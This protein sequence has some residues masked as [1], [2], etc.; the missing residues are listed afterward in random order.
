MTIENLKQ[1]LSAFRA[2]PNAKVCVNVEGRDFILDYPLQDESLEI[3][4]ELMDSLLSLGIIYVY[5]GSF[6]VNPMAIRVLDIM[7]A[8]N[9]DLT[10]EAFQSEIEESKKLYRGENHYDPTEMENHFT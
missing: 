3:N 4:P 10:E 1:F 8:E 5:G 6:E 9:K 2:N 7:H